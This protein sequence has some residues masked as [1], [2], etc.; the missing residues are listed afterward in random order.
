M[1][2]IS[3]T[4]SPKA[5]EGL[6]RLAEEKGLTPEEAL[7][8]FLEQQLAKKTKPNNTRGTVQPFRRRD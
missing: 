8:E 1:A 7:A 2:H 5:Y 6:V 3:T 4:L